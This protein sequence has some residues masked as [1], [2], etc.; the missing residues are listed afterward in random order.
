MVR[1]KFDQKKL[2]NKINRLEQK[3][4]INRKPIIDQWAEIL[5]VQHK[6]GDL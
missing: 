4:P 3:Y 2:P 1:K 5:V 6:V